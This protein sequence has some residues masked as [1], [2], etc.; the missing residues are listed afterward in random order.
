MR[1]GDKLYRVNR[2]NR[3]SRL[4]DHNFIIIELTG[5]LKVGFTNLLCFGYLDQLNL[6]PSDLIKSMRNSNGDVIHLRN[7]DRGG[8]IVVKADSLEEAAT[9]ISEVDRS[10]YIQKEDAREE[11][12]TLLQGELK[13]M[14]GRQKSLEET[15]NQISE[16]L[17]EL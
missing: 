10:V 13:A 4:E 5:H 16:S 12:K 7:G 14:M 3:N 11:V 6:C 15:I 9:K 8:V 17:K 2:D 1:V